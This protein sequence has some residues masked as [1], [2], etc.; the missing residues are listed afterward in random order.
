M[1]ENTFL[2]EEKLDDVITSCQKE[3][4][5]K[6]LVRLLGDVFTRSSS[7]NNSFP[8]QSNNDGIELE[9]VRKMYEVLFNLQNSAVENTLIN[10]LGTLSTGIEVELKRRSYVV[11]DTNFF[12]QFLII[13]ENPYLNQSEYLE[14]A[15]PCFCKAVSL[16]PVNIQLPLVHEWSKHSV[17]SI[18]KKVETLQLL[19]TLR[20]LNGPSSSSQSMTVNDD[21]VIVHAT[22]CMKLFHYASLL[23]GKF[24]NMEEEPMDTDEAATDGETMT[25]QLGLD[26]LDCREALLPFDA[27]INEPLNEEIAIDRD[28]TSYKRKKGFSFMECN[29][30]LTTHTKSI[31]MFYD[32]RVHMLQERRL[33]HLY[34]LLRGQVPTPYLKLTVRR[35]NLIQDALVNVSLY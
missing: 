22:K 12:K 2:T 9:S 34:S 11:N 28:F 5:F 15:L 27:F 7:L 24:D 19:I 18:R 14:N 31:C 20:V 26:V 1:Q 30:I 17:D 10:S 4:D 13:F 29:F 23:G 21:P 33:T 6:P 35:D 32:N 3:N 25:K 8:H 16:L